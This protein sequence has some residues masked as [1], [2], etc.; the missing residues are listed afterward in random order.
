MTYFQNVLRNK[1]INEKMMRNKNYPFLLLMENFKTTIKI[2]Y[3]FMSKRIKKGMFI[4]VGY[5]SKLQ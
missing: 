1:T 4:K 2:K 5:K 3:S